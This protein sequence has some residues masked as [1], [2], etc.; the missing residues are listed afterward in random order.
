MEYAGTGATFLRPFEDLPTRVRL[1]RDLEAVKGTPD[2]LFDFK[3]AGDVSALVANGLG[4][5]SLINAG[6]AEEADAHTLAGSGWPVA[7]R[8][9]P[10]WKRLYERARHFL[11]ASR[12][13]D[14]AA[15]KSVPMGAIA[16]MHGCDSHGLWT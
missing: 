16:A 2:G 14:G 13:P 4:G 7:W 1:R 11:R 12:W 15:G 6:V 5:G 9:P 10:K 8:D 3:L